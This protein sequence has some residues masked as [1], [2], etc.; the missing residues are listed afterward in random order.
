M[1]K[2]DDSIDMDIGIHIYFFRKTGYCVL[3]KQSWLT[4]QF[5]YTLTGKFGFGFMVPWP[6]ETGAFSFRKVELHVV[7]PG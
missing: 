7:C 4:A 2:R 3:K 1:T 6:R 5:D